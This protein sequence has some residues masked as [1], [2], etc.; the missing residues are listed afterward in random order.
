MKIQ[1]TYKHLH[2]LLCLGSGLRRT[3]SDIVNDNLPV[4]MRA[5]LEQMP[6]NHAPG[7]AVAAKKQK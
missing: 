4:K 2:Y 1:N 6:A 5:L 3:S 7:D